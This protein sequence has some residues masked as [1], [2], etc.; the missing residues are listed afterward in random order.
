MT[1]QCRSCTRD[2][3][4]TQKTG[5]QRYCSDACKPKAKEPLRKCQGRNC[6]SFVKRIWNHRY[7]SD[8]CASVFRKC[9]IDGCKNPKRSAK[10]AGYC[11]L[12]CAKVG[13]ALRRS[14]RDR[15]RR[16]QWIDATKFAKSPERWHL[17]ALAGWL[18]KIKQQDGSYEVL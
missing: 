2:F 6:T 14:E 9:R 1:R 5:N 10:G 16:T 7:C 11:S 8:A 4:L 3:Q 15:E 13:R 17:R 18:I 12:E